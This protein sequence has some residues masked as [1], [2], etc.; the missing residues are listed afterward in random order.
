ME[1]EAFLI[2][3]LFC[4]ILYLLHKMSSSSDEST[5]KEGVKYSEWLMRGYGYLVFGGAAMAVLA[6]IYALILGL[7]KLF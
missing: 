4:F 1:P 6:L 2:F 7:V 3:A 5:R